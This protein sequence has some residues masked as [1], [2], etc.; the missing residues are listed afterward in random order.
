MA[1]PASACFRDFACG[2]RGALETA[3]RLIKP[4]DENESLALIATNLEAE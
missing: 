3:A 4:G 1:E 2:F